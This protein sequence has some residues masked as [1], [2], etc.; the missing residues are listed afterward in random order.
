M[1]SVMSDLSIQGPAEN[2][3][4]R[5]PFLHGPGRGG[6]LLWHPILPSQRG[7]PYH[8]TCQSPSP[9]PQCPHQVVLGLGHVW[10][11]GPSQGLVNAQGSSV[12]LLHLLELALVLAQQGQVVELLGHI[13]VVGTQDLRTMDGVTGHWG[14]PGLVG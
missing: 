9:G 7:L 11:V 3:S 14:H 12:V 1:S 8:V 5:V 2:P 4:L 10:V 6:A 13:W